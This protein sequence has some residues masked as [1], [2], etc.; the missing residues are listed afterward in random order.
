MDRNEERVDL[1]KSSTEELEQRKRQAQLVF[2]LNHTMPMTEEYTQIL[3]ELFENQIGHGS[4]IVSPLQVVCA[5]QVKI[6]KNVFINSNSLLMGRGGI[7]IEDDVLIA[8]NVSLISN[9]HDMYQ[10]QVLL[11]KPVTV[12][13][14]AWIGAGAT[15]LPGVTVGRFAVIG[16]ASVVTHDVPDYTVVVGNPAKIVRMLDPKEFKNEKSEMENHDNIT[17]K[18]SLK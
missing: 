16:A 13:Q 9:N 6:G 11:C 3:K 1:R 4:S 8:A 10:R 12:R 5:D 17:R 14:G 7:T 15:I 2:K 18:E